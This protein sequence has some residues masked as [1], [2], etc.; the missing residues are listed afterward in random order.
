MEEKCDFD[1]YLEG[2]DNRCMFFRVYVVFVIWYFSIDIF[3]IWIFGD[4]YVDK[5]VFNDVDDS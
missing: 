5:G 2:V 1:D 3:Y 4:D